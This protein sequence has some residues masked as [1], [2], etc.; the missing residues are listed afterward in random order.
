MGCSDIH[1]LI[2]E[3]FLVVAYSTW[4]L[5]SSNESRKGS[6]EHLELGGEANVGVCGDWVLKV[7]VEGDGLNA[8][9]RMGISCFMH[10]CP[11]RVPIPEMENWR[12]VP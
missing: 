12:V 5:S 8:G 7:L 2:L 4:V 1:G 6:T 9:A 10:V 3:C 11:R